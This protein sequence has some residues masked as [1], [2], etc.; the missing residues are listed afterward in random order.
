MEYF[1]YWAILNWNISVYR[2]FFHM[3]G[4]TLEYGSDSSTPSKNW[5]SSY[6]SP[7]CIVLARV[8]GMRRNDAYRHSGF[9]GYDVD[10]IPSC[11]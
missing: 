11:K 8:V 10:R 7:S 3:L 6:S 1:L 9:D 4:L 5:K 2:T